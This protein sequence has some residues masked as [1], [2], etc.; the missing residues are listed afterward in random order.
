MT[1]IQI[2]KAPMPMGSGGFNPFTDE[3]KASYNETDEAEKGRMFGPIPNDD[4]DEAVALLRRAG[5]SCGIGV[6][7][8]RVDVGDGKTRIHFLGREPRERKSK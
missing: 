2:Q 5:T 3:L 8:K 7:V 6:S 1:E 4:V